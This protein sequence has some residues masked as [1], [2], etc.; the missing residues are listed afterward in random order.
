MN[1]V[2]FGTG[3]RIMVQV[4]STWFPLIDRN[5][6]AG[7]QDRVSVGLPSTGLYSAVRALPRDRSASPIPMHH[8]RVIQDGARHERREQTIGIE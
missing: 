1:S 7:A 3:H 2:Y 5:G 8:G 6:S 4:Q